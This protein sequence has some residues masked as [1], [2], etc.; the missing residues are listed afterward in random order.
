MKIGASGCQVNN[1]VLAQGHLTLGLVSPQVW[2]CIVVT[3]ILSRHIKTL[4]CEM[5]DLDQRS[6]EE[7]A[8]G[9]EVEGHGDMIKYPEKKRL[10]SNQGKARKVCLE[11][12][13]EKGGVL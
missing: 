11:H 6:G 2:G 3:D 10:C 8:K 4:T 9:S 12:K 7:R 5:R 13:G 1:V